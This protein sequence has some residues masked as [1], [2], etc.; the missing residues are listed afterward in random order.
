MNWFTDLQR[1]LSFETEET[2][3][4]S[5]KEFREDCSNTL[6]R[7]FYPTDQAMKRFQSR[8]SPSAKT[9]DFILTYLNDKHPNVETSFS[10][11]AVDKL[12]SKIRQHKYYITRAID[13]EDFRRKDYWAGKAN[14]L[15]KELFGWHHMCRKRLNDRIVEEVIYVFPNKNLGQVVDAYW[16]RITDNG[17]AFYAGNFYCAENSLMGTFVNKSTDKIMHPIHMVI[18]YRGDLNNRIKITT[19]FLNGATLSGKSVFHYPF[20]FVYHERPQG[21]VVSEQRFMDEAAKL[22]TRR[23]KLVEPQKLFSDGYSPTITDRDALSA[24]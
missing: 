7:K 13:L 19:G 22:I 2:F 4:T 8:K 14:I 21:S 15:S 1:E 3:I 17:P 23:P 10:E 5:L 12:S 24:Q 20:A 9:I 11:F 18:G 16:Y 6:L